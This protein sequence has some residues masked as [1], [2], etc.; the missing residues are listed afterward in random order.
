[1]LP[2]HFELNILKINFLLVIQG[3]YFYAHEVFFACICI[4]IYSNFL[5]S[6]I[7][8]QFED[9]FLLFF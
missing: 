6:Y 8:T 5:E 2:W 1:M 7:S 9:F 4:L 3:N